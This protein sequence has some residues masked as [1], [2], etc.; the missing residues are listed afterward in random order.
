MLGKHLE[1]H[2]DVGLLL[3]RLGFGIGFLFFHGWSKLVGGPEAWANLGS[4]ME[5]FGISFGWTFFGFASALTESI[6]GLLFA[7]GFL[8]QPIAALLAIN[9]LVAGSMH[10][11]NDAGSPAHAVKNM[12][13]FI[14]MIFVGPGRYSVDHWLAE[15][16]KTKT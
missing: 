2:R 10:I 3:V 8:F 5:I 4:T 13:V 15:R 16:G 9:M 6:G 7:A 12:V 1:R 14:G 11:I